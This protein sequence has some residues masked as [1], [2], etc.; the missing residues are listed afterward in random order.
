MHFRS[1]AST[2]KVHELLLADDCALSTT[3]EKEIQ[4]SMDLFASNSA[5]FQLTMSTNKTVA[6]HQQPPNAEYSVPRMHVDGTEL[7]HV[8]DFSYLGSTMSRCIRI[9]EEMAQ[10]NSGRSQTTSG[11]G[12]KWSLA[13]VWAALAALFKDSTAYL[14]SGKA[15]EN[16]PQTNAW[17]SCYRH[18]D[19]GSQ[20]DNSRSKR[21]NKQKPTSPSPA[22]PHMLLGCD[23]AG[24][25]F[26]GDLH[27]P[28]EEEKL[29]ALGE[30]NTRAG[31]NHAAW[32]GVLGPNEIGCRNVNGF[33]LL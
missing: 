30:F 31:K 33:L 26:F 8:D 16:V 13:V 22:P 21:P 10:T 9:D 27:S 23:E 29:V 20:M 4:R 14:L 2:A 3:A 11:C 28:S 17:E 24:T 19:R 18:A 15:L 7:K 25:N 5:H 1:R 6:M 32:R 12:P